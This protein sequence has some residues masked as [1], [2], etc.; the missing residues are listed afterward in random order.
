MLE[1]VVGVVLFATLVVL[2]L[3]AGVF[4]AVLASGA[5]L[6]AALMVAA[7]TVRG[8][9]GLVHARGFAVTLTVGLALAWVPYIRGRGWPRIKTTVTGQA[10]E[11]LRDP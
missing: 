11:Q 7:V 10:E 1:F 8:G 2:W 6:F 9:E 5:A 3:H 4:G